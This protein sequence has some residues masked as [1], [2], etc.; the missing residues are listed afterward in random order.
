MAGRNGTDV[1]NTNQGRCNITGE[2]PEE[3]EIDVGNPD[4]HIFISGQWVKHAAS[5]IS[6]PV[7]V[8][9]AAHA[10][11]NAIQATVHAAVGA[12]TRVSVGTRA[13]PFSVEDVHTFQNVV[14]ACDGDLA[15][16]GRTSL[17]TACS[18]SRDG[19]HSTEC[20]GSI[21][22]DADANST[23]ADT[24][25]TDPVL[26][27]IINLLEQ[28]AGSEND[29]LHV[30]QAIVSCALE[31]DVVVE[32]L[33]ELP[34]E[35]VDLLTLVTANPVEMLT[36]EA[37][38][39]LLATRLHNTRLAPTNIP[40]CGRSCQ[41]LC[42][43]NA[44]LKDPQRVLYNHSVCG[45]S[46]TGDTVRVA[47]VLKQRAARGDGDR[48]FKQE[49]RSG[50]RK[51]KGDR[52]EY[53]VQPATRRDEGYDKRIAH[54][55]EL[56]RGG[57]CCQ[58]GVS[59]I[60]NLSQA[61]IAK[62]NSDHSMARRKE[63][64]RQLPTPTAIL[65]KWGTGESKVIE[66]DGAN[67]G[68]GGG[69]DNIAGTSSCCSAHHIDFFTEDGVEGFRA[70]WTAANGTWGEENRILADLMFDSRSQG[71]GGCC[72]QLAALILP[73]GAERAQNMRLHLLQ[74]GGD[75]I[76]EHGNIGARPA[77]S[78]SLSRQFV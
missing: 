51:L 14:A 56:L 24:I 52:D 1:L 64:M 27:D 74:F 33:S 45:G 31:N 59:L 78:V 60:T 17:F 44:I 37:N 43:W 69:E 18:T 16:T 54:A 15:S 38:A 55:E 6:P 50:S 57:E 68:P 11:V 63:R 65:S 13:P 5:P 49:S 58:R 4:I 28:V 32:L 8:A 39:L 25:N 75:A 53:S 48:S 20:N 62:L 10:Q 34:V 19:A 2:M 41:K 21:D 67:G 35:A 9:A 71:P 70:S 76:M 77:N 7:N 42:V 36:Q 3:G 40:A 46:A 72:I 61:T 22:T 29:D 73:I 23:S 66:I 26:A 47:P 30:L 12:T